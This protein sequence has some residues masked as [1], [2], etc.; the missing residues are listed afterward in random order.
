MV[1]GDHGHA[2]GGVAGGDRVAHP[3]A[4]RIEHGLQA[5]QAQV[6]QL[7]RGVAGHGVIERGKDEHAPAERRVPSTSAAAS[8]AAGRQRGSIASGAPL[9]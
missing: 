1:A 2:P 5:E 4:R 7:P 6:V 9:A 8:A 3:G